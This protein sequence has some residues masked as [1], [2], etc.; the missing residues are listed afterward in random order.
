MYSNPTFIKKI[1]ANVEGRDFIVGDIHGCYNEF[2][3]LLDYVKFD[4]LRDRVFSTGDLLDRGPSPYE[5][6][7]LLKKPWFHAVL[8]NH[9]DI[10]LTRYMAIHKNDQKELSKLSKKDIQYVLDLEEFI[11]YVL[12]MPLV[13]EIEHLLLDKFYIVHA[14]VL[15]EHLSRFSEEESSSK[16]PSEK[17]VDYLNDLNKRDYSE[18]IA[19]FFEENED[20]IIPF[21][22]KQ[23]M[24][25]SRK[26]VGK[27]NREHKKLVE[28]GDFSFM[29]E[30]S[31]EQKY[32]IFCGHNVVPFPM[33]IGQQY[34]LD[35]GCALGYSDKEIGS[36]LFTL[37]GHEFFALTMVDVTSGYCF[38][39]ISTEEKRGQIVKLD[40]S[41]YEKELVEDNKSDD[42]Q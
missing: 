15:P 20:K 3:R 27:F 17:Y 32:K 1:K 6:L 42:E 8:G 22:L 24:I 19:G 13:Y 38:A 14:E 37:F 28:E 41:L 29:E 12:K 18:Q 33:K 36:N 7:N 35:T 10:L 4:P 5:C 23:E 39:C 21:K 11:P 9:E 26:L 16:T 30:E 40:K 2:K 31:F 25:W 34:Y